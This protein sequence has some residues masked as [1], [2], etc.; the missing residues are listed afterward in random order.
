MKHRDESISKFLS[1]LNVDTIK[2]VKFKNKTYNE[3]KC[4]CGQHIIIG[5]N[6]YNKRNGKTCTIGYKCL[7][8]IA[9]YLNW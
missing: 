5:Y 4:V 2:E 7:Q 6:F 3:T 1:K 8:Y 9:D